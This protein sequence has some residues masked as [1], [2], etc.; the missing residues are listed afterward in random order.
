M[1]FRKLQMEENVMKKILFGALILLFSVATWAQPY[2]RNISK[3]VNNLNEKYCGDLFKYADGT[4]ID[5]ENDNYAAASY[6]NILDWMQGRV[7]GLQI[8]YTRNRVPVPFIRNNMAAIYVDEQLVTA[9][10]LQVLPVADIAM[11]KVI[12]GSFVGAPGN[13][14]GGVIAIYTKETGEE[15]EQ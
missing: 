2:S 14:N 3:P 4:I 11:I 12:K 9:D 10:Y 7:A 15:E 6:L 5:L 8:Y 13:G 1:H